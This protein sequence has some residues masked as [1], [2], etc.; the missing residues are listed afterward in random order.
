MSFQ[1][2]GT[3][4]CFAIK[5]YFLVILLLLELFTNYLSTV[6]FGAV[7]LVFWR[8]HSCTSS[9]LLISRTNLIALSMEVQWN[10]EWLRVIV[11]SNVAART[12]RDFQVDDN[13][14]SKLQEWV[15]QWSR[16]RN[17]KSLE[18]KAAGAQKCHAEKVRTSSVYSRL[19]NSERR[20][21]NSIWN[22]QWQREPREFVIINGYTQEY[23]DG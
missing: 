19:K 14:N 20:H 10:W 2:K 21:K 12:L 8:D 18:D 17:F 16:R 23:S 13:N 5:E 9:P 11:H 6:C 7:F 1:G 4:N 22:F 3:R 15:K